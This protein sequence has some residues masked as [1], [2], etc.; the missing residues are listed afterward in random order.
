M[1][2]YYEVEFLNGGDYAI[3]QI[4]WASTIFEKSD[5]YDDGVGDCVHSYAFDGQ[6][7]VKFH[8]G[9]SSWGKKIEAN[10]GYRLGVA[11]DLANGQLMFGINGDWSPPMGVAFSGLDTSISLYPALSAVHMKVAV[12]FGN[13]IK[14]GPPDH[15]FRTVDD[16]FLDNN[17]SKY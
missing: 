11:A 15:S 7:V 6:R 8:D 3:S 1:K 9:A 4:G 17:R 14:F 12:Y 2:I 10:S 5:N 13:G 16:V